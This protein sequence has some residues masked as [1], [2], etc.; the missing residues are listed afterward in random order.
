MA[1]MNNQ[2]YDIFE[3]SQEITQQECQLRNTRCFNT[4]R[5]YPLPNLE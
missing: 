4:R 3:I 1:I 5:D 2:P